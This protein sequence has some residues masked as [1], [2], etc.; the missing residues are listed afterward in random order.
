[1]EQ[2]SHISINNDSIS[3]HGLIGSVLEELIK[4]TVAMGGE[5]G[6]GSGELMVGGAGAVVRGRRGGE[7][8]S[9]HLNQ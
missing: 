7:E 6:R 2:T 1:M 9:C 5:K 3:I 8:E 4:K